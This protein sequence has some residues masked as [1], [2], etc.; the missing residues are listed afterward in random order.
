MMKTIILRENQLKSMLKSM[1]QNII[2]EFYA[3]NRKD[4]AGDDSNSGHFK[5]IAQNFCIL[6]YIQMSGLICESV[7]HW[8]TELKVAINNIGR[9]VLKNN[10]PKNRESVFAKQARSLQE[11]NV[12]EKAMDNKFT[13]E[14]ANGVLKREEFIKPAKQS[15]YD[16]LGS[17]V[18]E[19]IYYNGEES[20]DKFV[21]NI[22]PN[23]A[24]ATHKLKKHGKIG[25]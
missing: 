10:V 11:K 5:Q 9:I 24:F 8:K 12:F 17:I 1:V 25:K 4:I 3:R 14:F 21:D 23:D 7:E 18:N 13:K 16:N 2:N 6:S 20:I 22:F 19:L 15:F